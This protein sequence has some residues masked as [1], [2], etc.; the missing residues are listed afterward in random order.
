MSQPELVAALRAARP[1]APPELRERVRMLAVDAA[2]SGSA[3]RRRLTWRRALVIAVPVAAA[4]AA[5]VVLL[6]RGGTDATAPTPPL[7]ERA[8]S[9]TTA[10]A[11]AA[12]S[13]A[14]KAATADSVGAYRALPA[15][16]PS[17]PQKYSAALELRLHDSAAVSA[18]S[19]RAT[20]IVAALGGYPSSL[21]V[22][23]GRA[24]GYASLV[25]RVPRSRVETAVR[26]LS[27]LGTIVNE[28]VRIQDLGAQVSAADRTLQRLRKQ[29]AVLRA[30]PQTTEVEQRVAALEGADRETAARPRGD[31]PHRE[32]RDRDAPARLAGAEDG[33]RRAPR[34][35]PAARARDRVPLARDRRGLRA[36]ARA[37]VRAARRRDLAR[38]ASGAPA[39]RGRAAQP[40]L[41]WAKM[42]NVGSPTGSS[43]N[44]GFTQPCSSVRDAYVSS[45]S[46]RHIGSGCRTARIAPK[47]GARRS[48][49]REHVEVDLDVEHLLHAADVRVPPR[50]VRV[51]ER[52]ARERHAPGYTTLS[53]WTPQRL[54]SISSW[55]R[56]GSRDG[57]VS[58]CCIPLI[59]GTSPGPRK[60]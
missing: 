52:T 59:V 12:G 29:L 42:R 47:P 1:S 24:A 48:A 55:G 14:V 3:P 22:D 46:A 45:T 17:R 30:E 58:C 33:G 54:H 37:A 15:P 57:A 26:R 19:R 49:A 44:S 51:D 32:P 41:S 27:S 25:F 38:R 60:T 31:A 56:S 53:Q 50:L 16:S 11:G 7:V 5:A 36:R 23:A 34:P 21:N 10:A 18:A 35:R 13:G 20:A 43:P 28:N 39:A 4:V 40:V 2:D 6:P 8:A 9:P